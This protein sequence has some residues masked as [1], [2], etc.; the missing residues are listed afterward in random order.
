MSTQKPAG[1]LDVVLLKLFIALSRLF[2]HRLSLKMAIR[3]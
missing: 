1:A 3:L 2:A